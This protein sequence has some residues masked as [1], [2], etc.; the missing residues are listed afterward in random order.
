MDITFQYTSTLGSPVNI[1]NVQIRG[2]LVYIHFLISWNWGQHFCTRHTLVFGMHVLWQFHNFSLFVLSAS[3]RLELLAVLFILPCDWTRKPTTT[4]T[5]TKLICLS[6]PNLV[7]S[8]TFGKCM[9]NLNF[10]RNC[11]KSIFYP[12]CLNII[13]SKNTGL[14]YS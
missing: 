1:L 11:P 3:K 5:S 13:K 7:N 4:E 8:I 12:H 9:W 2:Q 6:F 10:Q 14:M